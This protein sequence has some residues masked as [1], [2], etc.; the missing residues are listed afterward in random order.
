MSN[1]LFDQIGAQQAAPQMGQLVQQ[2]KSNPAAML[3]QRGFNIPAGM[4][5]PQHIINHLISSGQVPQS[6]YAQLLQNMQQ[7]RR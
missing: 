6:R 1:P 7:V 4:N 3:Q 2:I 5:N